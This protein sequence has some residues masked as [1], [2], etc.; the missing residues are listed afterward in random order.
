MIPPSSKSTWG[1][2]ITCAL[3]KGT[4]G[5]LRG[6]TIFSSFDE[7]QLLRI[8]SSPRHRYKRNRKIELQ[9][10]SEIRVNFF[11]FP[12]SLQTM[13]SSNNG[14]EN[15]FHKNKKRT[16]VEANQATFR[17]SLQANKFVSGLHS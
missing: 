14:H 3:S 16:N 11:A 2:K 5:N 4:F 7:I 1:K 9:G 8:E 10:E 6:Q 12:R 13:I 15:V 17:A